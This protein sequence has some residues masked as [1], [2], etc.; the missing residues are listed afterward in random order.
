MPSD[1]NLAGAG[2]ELLDF[3]NKESLLKQHLSKIVKNYDYTIIDFP[4]AL[5]L[6]TIN[7]LT[8]SDT[9]LIPIQCEYY[10]LE[11]LNQVLKRLDW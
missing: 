2:I 7:A 4:P 8:A 6:L 11:G 10:A 1:V 9:V 3:E 5:S